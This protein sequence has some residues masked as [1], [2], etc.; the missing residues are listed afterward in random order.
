MSADVGRSWARPPA[1]G[2]ARFNSGS[3]LVTPQRVQE[4]LSEPEQYPSSPQHPEPSPQFG[5][6]KGAETIT[7]KAPVAAPS[8]GALHGGAIPVH[9]PAQLLLLPREQPCVL[10]LTAP[11]E[12]VRVA[13]AVDPLV[14]APAVGQERMPGFELRLLS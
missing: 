12:E 3:P 9:L 13:P 1:V 11:Y 14:L 6:G 7:P 4:P 2:M 5:A 8:N 10:T